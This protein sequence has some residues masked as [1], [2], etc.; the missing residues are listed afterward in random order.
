METTLQAKVESD[1]VSIKKEQQDFDITK[2]PGENVPT[3]CLRLNAIARALG[4]K[5]L[6]S[7]TICK[8]LEG[9]S[10]PSD[11]EWGGAIP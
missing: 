11:K 4:D 5:D 10:N 1:I 2:F 9:F 8:V 6:P 7:N 3:A